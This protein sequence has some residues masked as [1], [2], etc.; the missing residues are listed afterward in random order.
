LRDVW[1]R[2]PALAW[3][4]HQLAE[5]LAPYW[6]SVFCD[7][8]CAKVRR[9]GAARGARLV[10]ASLMDSA[11]LSVFHLLDEANESG[12]RVLHLSKALSR[13][14]VR[15]YLLLAGER[16]GTQQEAE[17][18]INGLL[19]L[20]SRLSD[21]ATVHGVNL[22]DAMRRLGIFRNT[23][24]AHGDVDAGKLERITHVE[25]RLLAIRAGALGVGILRAASAGNLDIPLWKLHGRFYR[26]AREAFEAVDPRCPS[27]AGTAA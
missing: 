16:L 22:P 20:R 27:P 24:L 1:N 8:Y 4:L 11:V 23:I 13:P 2:L 3:N 12:C 10:R 18:A 6:V 14:E 19:S 17:A 25:L 26:E 5:R 9:Q 21:K 7:S 15:G